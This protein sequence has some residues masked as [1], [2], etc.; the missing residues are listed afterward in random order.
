[1]PRQIGHTWVFGTETAEP[2]QSWIALTKTIIDNLRSSSLHFEA[3][4]S[5]ISNQKAIN[6][7]AAITKQYA[8][9]RANPKLSPSPSTVSSPNL[10]NPSS[11]ITSPSPSRSVSFLDLDERDFA[12]ALENPSNKRPLSDMLK[13]I[14]RPASTIGKHGKSVIMESPEGTHRSVSSPQ[15]TPGSKRAKSLIDVITLKS[16]LMTELLEKVTSSPPK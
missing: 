8:T 3:R 6:A 4:V 9:M 10:S 14:L 5:K 13:R 12:D 16:I 15:L 1:M 11:P 2:K 7:R